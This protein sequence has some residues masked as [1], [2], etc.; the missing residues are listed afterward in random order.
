M[1]IVIVLAIL[2]ALYVSLCVIFFFGQHLFFFRPEILPSHFNYQYAFPFE[3]HT[4]ETGDGGSINAIHFTV[5]NRRGVVFYLKGNSR[6]IKGWGKFARD[7]LG[8]GYDFFMM[9]YRGFGK[10]RGRRSEK[11][12]YA[13][14]LRIYDWLSERYADREIILYGR[15]FG[16]GIAAYLAS[17]VRARLLILDSPY[18]SFLYQIKRFAGFLPLRWLLQ[19]QL[20]TYKYLGDTQCPVY[21]I[22]GDRDYL[23]SFKQSEMLRDAYPDTVVLIPIKGGW[24]NNLPQLSQY[25][26]ALYEILNRDVHQI[27]F[28]TSDSV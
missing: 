19:Y 25:H 15:S 6:S 26:E 27:Q 8:K 1:W 10:S 12:L 13:D 24:H 22:H 3:E 20:P 16:S 2:A 11:M 9:D 7:F 18:Y 23:I 14:A 21:I 4:F 5:P 17:K 28:T